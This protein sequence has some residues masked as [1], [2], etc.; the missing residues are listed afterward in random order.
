MI[1]TIQCG[2][3][4]YYPTWGLSQIMKVNSDRSECKL[5]SLVLADG[6]PIIDR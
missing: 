3:K 4:G 1:E 5:I 6:S 2:K